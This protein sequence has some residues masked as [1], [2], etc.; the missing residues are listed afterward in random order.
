[1]GSPLHESSREIDETQHRVT[2]AKGY[3]LG[4]TPITQEQWQA[5]VGSN[6]SHFKVGANLPVEKVTW[7]DCQTFCQKVGQA[8]GHQFRLPSEAEWEYACRAGTTTA[9]WW[10]DSSSADRMNHDANHPCGPSARK[11]DYRQKTTPVGSFPASAWGL[12]DTHGNV[13]E[14]CQDWI[15]AYPTD[16]IQD[17]NNPKGSE[18]RVLRGGSWNDF[19]RSCRA[20]HRGRRAPSFRVDSVGCRVVLCED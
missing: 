18:A 11:G 16:E 12:F 19:A 14:W 5:V 4:A 8:T 3:W 10:G 6:P 13:W 15:G 20:A 2:L 17:P 7:H 1:M 9:F